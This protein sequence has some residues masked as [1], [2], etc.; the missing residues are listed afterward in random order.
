MHMK[1]GI[2]TRYKVALQAFKLR[3]GSN[4][5]QVQDTQGFTIVEVMVVLAVTGAL[6]ISAATLISG[7]QNKTQFTVAANNIKTQIQQVISDVSTGFYPS[8]NNINCTLDNTTGAPKFTAG[9]NTQGSN[10]ACVFMGKAMEFGIANTDPEQFWTY[11]LAG[12]R[13]KA[14]GADATSISEAKPRVMVLNTASP[15]D[16]T[17]AQSSLQNGLTTGKMTYTNGG[18]TRNIVAVAFI[19]DLSQ[20]SNGLVTGAQAVNV[21]PIESAVGQTVPN[22]TQSSTVTS[23]NANITTGVTNPSGGVSICFLSGGTQQAAV[24]T[25]GGSNQRQNAVTLSIRSTRTCP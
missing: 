17:T 20:S 11:S 13:V 15:N 3:F 10:E 19:S 4:G 12:L 7:R 23:I 18:T 2:A 21:V 25:I 14:N 16:A 5:N 8:A 22:T 24:V 9:T 1:G 6:F